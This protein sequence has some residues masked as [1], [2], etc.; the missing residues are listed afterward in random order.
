MSY[1]QADGPEG[2]TAE[3]LAH[4]R[5]VADGAT[6]GAWLYVLHGIYGAGRNWGSV[7]RALVERRP[8]WGAVLVDLRGH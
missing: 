8:D 4:E 5:V 2:Q 1:Q 3:R 6:P 7:A